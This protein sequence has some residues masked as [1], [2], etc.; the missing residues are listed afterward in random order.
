[1]KELLFSVIE[2][3]PNNNA[4]AGDQAGSVAALKIVALLVDEPH[5]M[6]LWTLKKLAS[7]PG[8]LYALSARSGRRGSTVNHLRCWAREHGL[9]GVASQLLA[10]KTI[11][12][13]QNHNELQSMH[14]LLDGEY[15]EEW[16][17]N[18]GIEPIEVPH[19][20]HADARAVITR[21]Q[22]DIIVRVGG[23]M[24]K[25][26]TVSLARIA[27]LNIHHGLGPRIRGTWSIPWGIIEGRCDWIGATVHEI[28]DGIDS[29][30][31]LWR[32]S[33]Q[34]APGDSGTTLL[35][36]VHLEAVDA[37]VTAIRHYATGAMPASWPLD[38][39]EQSVC[40]S[41]PGVWAWLRYLYLRNGKHASVILERAWR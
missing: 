39:D 9:R 14:R 11:G 34:L 28:E 41:A 12:L 17:C 31:I 30:R 18:S 19:L 6:E 4:E 10:A 20:N 26:E 40:R 22:P 16:W 25:R 24:L 2:H 3:T 13:C 38:E 5:A 1:L 32:G 33:P 37:L 35:F 29:G 21:L 7:I 27:T 23:E 15:L 8:D 36:R